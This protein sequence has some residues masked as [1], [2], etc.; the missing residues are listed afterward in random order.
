MKAK[1]VIELGCGC[2]AC[3][4]G[5]QGCVEYPDGK[6]P[7][8]TIREH[9]DAWI[10]VRL[11]AAVAADEECEKAAGM[12]DDQM[13]R[14]Q[15]AQRRASRG[16]HPDDFAAFDSGEMAGY[17]PDGSWIPGPNAEAFADLDFEQQKEDSPL[18]FP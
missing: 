12:T 13:Q 8:G 5:S 15:H 2:E 7:I 1:T 6:I 9:P 14:A 3:C 10:L 17:N 16:I 11:G 18:Y 4:A